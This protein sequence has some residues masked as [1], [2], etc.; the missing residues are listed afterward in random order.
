[1]PPRQAASSPAASD[2]EALHVY[3]T[4][5]VRWEAVARVETAPVL[6][7]YKAAVTLRAL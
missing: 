7:T 2:A 3:L 1:M 5:R 4:Q 6:R